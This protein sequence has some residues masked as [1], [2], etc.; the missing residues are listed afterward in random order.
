MKS[1]VTIACLLLAAASHCSAGPIVES[2]DARVTCAAATFESVKALG[3][4]LIDEYSE[5][6]E[7]L[8]T[9]YRA[10]EALPAGGERE[11][12][13]LTFG[14]RVVQV[15]LSLRPRLQDIKDEALRF[16]LEQ[17][18]EYFTCRQNARS[19]LMAI[20]ENTP[21]FCAVV[22]VEWTYFSPFPLRCVNI[23]CWFLCTCSNL[24]RLP[25]VLWLR[26]SMRSS[27]MLTIC[28]ARLSDA[29]TRPKSRR[30]AAT[31]MFC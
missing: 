3:L 24:T 6:L 25:V 13:H 23:C 14:R 20:S 27:R 28:A 31:T 19:F 9:N 26:S 12:C 4:R 10:C 5:Q 22:S 8:R 29:I 7:T 18:D 30:P 2:V 21:S 11:E 1:F 15:L 16:T 17:L